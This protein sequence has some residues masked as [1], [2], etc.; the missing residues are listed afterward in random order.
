MGRFHKDLSLEEIILLDKV[1]K[2]QSLSDREAKQLKAKNLIEGRKPN[3][4]IGL[5]VAE[6]TGLK[7]AYSKN[8]ALDKSY[9]LDLIEKAI[10]QHTSLQRRDVDEL[11]WNKLPE[12][13]DE[14]QRKIKINNLL[15]ELRRN[16]IIVN[17]GTYSKPKWELTASNKA[18]ID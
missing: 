4:Y 3:Y 12:W 7:A 18:K 15:S 8:K 6:K 9:Y 10:K 14:K 13:M 17:S 5:K 1:Q 2:K 16:G 11:L